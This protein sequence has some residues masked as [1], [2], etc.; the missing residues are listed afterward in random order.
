MG[1]LNQTIFSGPINIREIVAQFPVEL[2][3]RAIEHDAHELM[4]FL[5]DQ[6]DQTNLLIYDGESHM[7]T[8]PFQGTY[9]RKLKCKH[10]GQEKDPREE[11]FEDLSLELTEHR[12]TPLH[13]NDLLSDF[14]TAPLTAMCEH[15]NINTEMEQSI[16]LSK[17][18][19]ILTI[20]LKRFKYEHTAVIP[21]Y[22]TI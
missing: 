1:M 12:Q 18:P 7:P 11:K 19:K 9:W 2:A 6:I 3:N 15:C 13:L 4:V 20:H 21:G 5:R 16:I 14:M 17:P 8:T 22:K 10:C